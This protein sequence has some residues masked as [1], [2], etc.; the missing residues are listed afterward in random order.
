[1]KKDWDPM[2]AKLSLTSC[3]KASVAVRIPSR[4]VMP[5]A[6][7]SIVRTLLSL[8]LLMDLRATFTFSLTSGVIRT[9][10]FLSIPLTFRAVK[11]GKIV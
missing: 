6:I 5:M 11:V 2:E 7:I 3:F 1:M 8:L 9:R 4:E 10:L